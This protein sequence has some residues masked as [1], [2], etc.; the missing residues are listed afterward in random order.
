MREFYKATVVIEILSESK[1]PDE[2][3][4][5]RQ[6]EDV[7]SSGKCIASIRTQEVKQLFGVEIGQAIIDIAE[8][9]GSL[10]D[11]D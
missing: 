4:S 3:T 5:L 7:I 11:D 9:P 8:G 6:I 1:I 2:F 10:D